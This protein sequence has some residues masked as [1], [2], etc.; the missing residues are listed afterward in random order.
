MSTDK[1]LGIIIP[2]ERFPE[3]YRPVVE[4][5]RGKHDQAKSVRET[6]QTEVSHNKA[7]VNGMAKSFG[8]I[9]DS[10]YG[11]DQDEVDA[12]AAEQ[13]EGSTS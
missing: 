10:D 13:A 11:A 9:L 8:L 6:A 3:E 7:L 5:L 2:T 4:G 12:S 1:K